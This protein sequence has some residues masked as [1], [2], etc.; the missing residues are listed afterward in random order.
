ML[1]C[2]S[3]HILQKLKFGKKIYFW[4]TRTRDW[5]YSR[6]EMVPKAGGGGSAACW[7]LGHIPEWEAWAMSQEKSVWGAIRDE[8]RGLRGCCCPT[9]LRKPKAGFRRG[10]GLPMNCTW[11][12][13]WGEEACGEQGLWGPARGCHWF[14]PSFVLLWALVGDFFLPSL[15]V[16][17]CWHTDVKA[18]HK[19]TRLF[20]FASSSKR[21]PG[22]YAA[23]G[24]AGESRH[25]MGVGTLLVAAL[26]RAGPRGA[27]SPP[28][29]ST[30]PSTAK[31]SWVCHEEGDTL[32][33]T[34]PRC[35]ESQSQSENMTATCFVHF[36]PGFRKAIYNYE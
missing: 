6:W 19:I 30:R 8:G 5:P 26:G 11:G 7:G 13:G 25:V 14:N 18:K 9:W 1:A 17:D 23:S 28:M 36:S 29:P 22:T 33:G 21:G 32:G 24:R 20:V 16:A 35:R 31:N 27:D 34:G 3:I 4:R 15:R 12:A 10:D 2:T